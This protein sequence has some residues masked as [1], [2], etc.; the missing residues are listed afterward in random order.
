MLSGSDI[1][2][3]FEN[4]HGN[5][6][7]QRVASSKFIRGRTPRF[8]LLY[9]GRTL[10]AEHSKKKPLRFSPPL[11]LP[12]GQRCVRIC[13]KNTLWPLKIEHFWVAR[14]CLVVRARALLSETSRGRG[15]TASVSRRPNC[16]QICPRPSSATL[17]GTK[18]GPPKTAKNAGGGAD[19]ALFW[20][21]L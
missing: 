9:E 4:P 13:A 3:Y 1:I 20:I 19:L 5:L 2:A 10:G 8:F 12:P 14:H 7:A 15:D 6:C 21:P 16:N 18:P 11:L 17:L